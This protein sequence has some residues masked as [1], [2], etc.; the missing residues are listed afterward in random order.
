M[1]YV[2]KGQVMPQHIDL[3][4]RLEPGMPVYPGLPAP[5]FRTVFT[6][7]E[8]QQQARYAPGTTF[9]IAAYDL[10]GNT[11]TYIDA[12][13]HRHPGGPDLAELAL[14]KCADLPGALIVA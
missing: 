10:G 7:Q 3:S 9:Q 13:F 14:D 5:Q 8:A 11:G 1:F 2:P 6:H 12:P 4:Y